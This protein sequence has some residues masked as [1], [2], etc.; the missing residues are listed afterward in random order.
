MSHLVM[1]EYDT[2]GDK[3]MLNRLNDELKA[4][5]VRTKYQYQ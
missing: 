3:I 2:S 4:Y 5:Q 1:Y